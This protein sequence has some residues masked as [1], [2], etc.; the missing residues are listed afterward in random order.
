MTDEGRELGVME[1]SGG[2][3]I[4]VTANTFE[5]YDLVDV[6]EYFEDEM[7][8]PKPTRKGISLRREQFGEFVD[9]LL[10][11]KEALGLAD[12]RTEVI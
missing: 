11:A 3:L 2:R 12:V 7:G 1:K 4:R 10:Q 9:M 8:A 5:G 6:R